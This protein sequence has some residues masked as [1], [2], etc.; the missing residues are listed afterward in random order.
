MKKS[1]LT[2]LSL[3]LVGGALLACAPQNVIPSPPP[4]FVLSSPT[5]TRSDLTPTPTPSPTPSPTFTPT[6][7]AT[8]TPRPIATATPAPLSYTLS[9][10]ELN[11]QVQNAVA[12]QPDLPVQNLQVDLR[13]GQIVLLGQVPAGFFKL[14]AEV[15][16]VVK[17]VAGK[18]IPEIASIKVAGQAVGG[19][20]EQQI[21][22]LIQPYIDQFLN[23]DLDVEIQNV[24]IDDTQITIEA[25]RP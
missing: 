19:I 13:P 17:V 11:R 15:I 21:N 2:L 7:T 25:K 14:N 8:P 18:A 22:E 9:E 4:T 20:L 10:S 1:I 5:P 3:F 16:L 24:T 23:T 6:P 12:D